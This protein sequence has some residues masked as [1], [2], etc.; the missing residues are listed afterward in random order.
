MIASARNFHPHPR[1]EFY[2]VD[3]ARRLEQGFRRRHGTILALR[4]AHIGFSVAML[5]AVL[6]DRSHCKNLDPHHGFEDQHIADLGW[7]FRRVLS[8]NPRKPIW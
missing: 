3:P 8:K 1:I 6:D 2:Q 4:I 7:H 5:L